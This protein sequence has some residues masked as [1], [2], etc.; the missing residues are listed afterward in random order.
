MELGLVVLQHED[1]HLFGLAWVHL[2][3]IPN[4]LLAKPQPAVQRRPVPV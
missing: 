2:E 1:A 4:H 3:Q